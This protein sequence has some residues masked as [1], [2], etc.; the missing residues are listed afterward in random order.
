MYSLLF[1]IF[2]DGQSIAL[3]LAKQIASTTESIKRAI[4]KFNNHSKDQ[5]EGTLYNLPQS[6]QWCD[7]F[8]LEGMAN[9]ELSSHSTVS[10]DTAL[11]NRA[12]RILHMNHRAQEEI[13]M[14]K[15]DMK[16]TAEFY[17]AEHSLLHSHLDRIRSGIQSVYNKGCLN[18][19][20]HR[21]VQCEFTLTHCAK[22][23]VPHIS[24]EFPLCSLIFSLFD[25]T[26]IHTDTISTEDISVSS[27]IVSSDSESSTAPESDSEN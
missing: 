11:L 25:S 20:S 10:V 14:V 22:A 13:R 6:L 3:R 2:V 15:E 8:D 21:L 12:V 5:F 19:L 23:F 1:L 24:F 26:S 9:L 18:L 16:R 17:A 27:N 4:S 7:I